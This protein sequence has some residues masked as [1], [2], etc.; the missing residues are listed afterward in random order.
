MSALHF[1]IKF[2]NGESFNIVRQKSGYAAPDIIFLLGGAAGDFGREKL[3]QVK[4]IM[5]I[6]WETEKIKINKK[7]EKQPATNFTKIFDIQL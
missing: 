2:S 6:I 7:S 1:R 4:L 5:N 3:D